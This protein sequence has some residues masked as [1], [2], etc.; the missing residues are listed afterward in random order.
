MPKTQ[1]VSF[2][3]LLAHQKL[4]QAKNEKDA[5]KLKDVNAKTAHLL[6][7]I[8]EALASIPNLKRAQNWRKSVEKLQ[9]EYHMPRFVIG[10]LGDTGS[11][12]SSLINAVLDEERVV[13]TNC[14]RACTAVI[15]EISWNQSEDPAKKYRAEIEF[16]TQ[17]EWTTEVIALHR[18][19]LDHNGRISSDVRNPDS[20][21]GIAYAVLK[22]VY[23]QYTDEQLREADPAV[24]ASLDKVQ[25]VLGKTQIVEEGECDSF[26]PKIRSFVDSEEKRAEND[27]GIT[28]T[29]PQQQKMAFWPLIK[30][31]R[32]F[33]K[34]D[35]VS[36]GAVIVDLPGGRDSN[37]TRAAVA[38]KYV[39]ECSRLWVVAPINRAVDDKTARDLM[40]DHFKQQLKYDGL[41]NNITFICTK[42]DEISI[43]EA[44][45]SL[46]IKQTIIEA[47]ERAIQMEAQMEENKQELA[48]LVH[49][50]SSILV[51]QR[52]VRTE[53]DTWSTLH[54][55]VS[56]G[57]TAFAP[58]ISPQKRKRSRLETENEAATAKKVKKEVVSSDTDDDNSNESDLGESDDDDDCDQPG[59]LTQEETQKKLNELKAVKKALKDEKH[60]LTKRE[61]ELEAGIKNLKQQ[62]SATKNSMY[63]VCIQGRN[64]YTRSHI[65]KDFA[66]GLKELDEE[67]LAEQ[68]QDITQQVQG[69]TSDYKQIEKDLP[70]FCIS[71][72]GY[73]QLRKRMKKDRRV[74]G[75]SSLDDT[76]IPGL[77]THTIQLAAS[78]QVIHFRHHLSEICRLLG[79][80][81][82]FVAGD[83]ANNKLSDKEKQDET[84]NIEKSL[85][86][87]GETLSDAIARCMED[88]HKI[89][90]QG[91]LKHIGS[92]AEKAAEKALSTA[93]GWGA[94]YDAGGLRY[95][96]YK[97][98]CRRFHSDLL[99][100]LKNCTAYDWDLTFHSRLPE[101][102]TSLATSMKQLIDGFHRRMKD[103]RFLVENNE[104]VS[105]VFM[106]LLIAQK[107]TLIHIGNEQQKLVNKSGK[108]ANRLFAPVIQQAMLQAYNTCKNQYGK[109]CFITMKRIMATHVEYTK[110]TMFMDA[111]REIEKAVIC[112]L[113]DV[114]K[115][116]RHDTNS[117]INAMHEDYIGLVGE[118]AN[119]ADNR[120]RKILGP[121]VTEFYKKLN[122]ALTPAP[123]AAAPEE[124]AAEEE[125]AAPETIDVGTKREA[126]D[127][128]YRPGDDD[129][130]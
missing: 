96:T 75:F 67:L 98:I 14:M 72:R 103:R 102:L 82:L 41:Y 92:G 18:E 50:K 69:D 94:K 35:A 19:I 99:K 89:M 111:A 23:P 44:A 40:G 17:A 122:V 58:S 97:A 37:A 63:S 32:V 113:R 124:A 29:T 12:K 57:R 53:V 90:K 107:E 8:R 21:A 101:K 42:A 84:E 25:E 16:I 61:S 130:D 128:E 117:V 11:G 115:M 47:Q 66:F 83:V 123:E 13:P 1:V 2:T 5:T 88:C 80:L 4:E 24:L 26:Y 87:L 95:Q 70:V 109:G 51:K 74:V 129:S 55:Q 6:G 68:Q 45:S 106:K 39:K 3:G 93:E 118:V 108:E 60:S 52:I 81:D 112:M 79:A 78:I 65:K 127:D 110:S 91:I 64:K 48:I 20:D 15:T 56:K 22:T 46:G 43:E 49:Q 100:P 120:A 27:S 73:Q 86:E 34:S 30:V 119:E 104:F 7:D 33:L 77:R 85:S 76:E 38:A 71:S 125:E 59:P 9:D 116:I 126:S 121:V 31:V 36:T 10:V 54:K 62:R 28:N 114:E 105:E